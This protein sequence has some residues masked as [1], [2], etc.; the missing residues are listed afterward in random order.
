MKKII[1]DKT[2]NVIKVQ[3]IYDEKLKPSKTQQQFKNECDVNKIIARFNKTGELTHLKKSK[4]VFTDLTY[5]TDYQTAL[6]K[7]MKANQ[8]FSELNSQTRNRF[9]NDPQNLVNFLQ[10]PKNK[11]EAIELGLIVAPSVTPPAPA[12][13]PK[14]VPPKSDK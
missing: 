10:D 9:G 4:G 1:K 3:T 14:E 11:A 12:E 7:V 13:P 8:A 5:V 6:D 2:G